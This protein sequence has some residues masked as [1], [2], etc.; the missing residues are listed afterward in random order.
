MRF[1]NYISPKYP[2]KNPS[3]VAKNY[4]SVFPLLNKKKQFHR[5]CHEISFK[6]VIP[7]EEDRNIMLGI[8]TK[9]WVTGSGINSSK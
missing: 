6:I 3:T 7:D 4:Y 5:V 2:D 1:R 9:G 8:R